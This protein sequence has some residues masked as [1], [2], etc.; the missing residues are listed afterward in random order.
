MPRACICVQMLLEKFANKQLTVTESWEKWRTTIEILREKRIEHERKI[1]ESTKVQ[2]SRIQLFLFLLSKEIYRVLFIFVA[3]Q[4]LFDS[5]YSFQTMEWVSKFSDQLYPVITSLSHQTVNIL[6][7][8]AGSKDR[9]LPELNKAVD[10]LD[11]RIKGL[12]A[13]AQK[14]NVT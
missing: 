2:I 8:L 3:R 10:E 5:V 11:S 13:L 14:G 4:I 9:I 1:E 6:Q 7:D 12:N